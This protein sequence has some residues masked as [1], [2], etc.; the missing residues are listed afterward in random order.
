MAPAG[1]T[2]PVGTP[3]PVHIAIALSFANEKELFLQHE[4]YPAYP[5]Y[6]ARPTA[7]C[8]VCEAKEGGG[9]AS[10]TLVYHRRRRI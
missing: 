5:L 9:R 6:G 7:A 10:H 1:S 4:A 2:G 8:N 3:R